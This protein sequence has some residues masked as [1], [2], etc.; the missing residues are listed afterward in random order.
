VTDLEEL[1]KPLG[2]MSFREIQ[3]R[4]HQQAMKEVE[5]LKL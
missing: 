1:G 2:H 5:T 4:V 3:K